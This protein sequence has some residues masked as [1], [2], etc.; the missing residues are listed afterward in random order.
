MLRVPPLQSQPAPSSSTIKKF[1]LNAKLSGLPGFS[2][3]T[4]RFV[5]NPR[6]THRVSRRQWGKEEGRGSAREWDMGSPSASLNGLFA[7]PLLHGV[8]KG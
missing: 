3:F 4:Q 1:Y 6:N 2:S 7:G 5:F 8:G